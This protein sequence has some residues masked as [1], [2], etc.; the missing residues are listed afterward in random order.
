MGNISSNSYCSNNNQVPFS[1]EKSLSEKLATDEC[2]V[3]TTE[4]GGHRDRA[5]T[6]DY[7]PP[8]PPPRM[9]P[10]EHTRFSPPASAN[11]RR[12]TE[13]AN[14]RRAFPAN[15]RRACPA[16]QR[17]VFVRRSLSYCPWNCRGSHN[18]DRFRSQ[19][20]RYEK[21]Y[22]VRKGTSGALL[23]AIAVIYPCLAS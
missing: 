19:Y 8:C 13:A 3:K 5:A 20:L 15:K 14:Q 17:R 2:G 11:Q 16:N 4:L 9:R 12:A 21:R 18:Y 7:S 1:L 23:L 10:N 6:S 22:T